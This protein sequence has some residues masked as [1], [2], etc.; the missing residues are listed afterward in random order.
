MRLFGPLH[1]GLLAGIAGLAALLSVLCRQRHISG[2]I[3]RLVLGYGLAANEF[4]WWIFRYSHEGFRFPENLPLQ[5]CDLGVW[6]TVLACI[7]RIPLVVEFSYFG[8]FAAAAMA[9][10]TPDLWSPWPSY[11]AIYFFLA[12]G[13]II[14]AVSVLVFGRLTPLR[15]GAIWRAFLM[16]IAY[17]AFVGAFDAVFGTNY[18]YL[19]RKPK[20]LSLLDVLGPWPLYLLTSAAVALTLFWL[21]WLPVRPKQRLRSEDSRLTERL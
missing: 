1:L 14:V 18:M 12:H 8:A 4:I 2:R 9:V 7:S 10:L 19:C 15:A 20:H 16:L 6:S 5:L 17:L 3:L 11:P 13:G 21:M